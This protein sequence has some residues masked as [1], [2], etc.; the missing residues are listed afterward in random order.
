[1]RLIIISWGVCAVAVVTL[2]GCTT[3]TAIAQPTALTQAYNH[4]MSAYKKL[5]EATL[6]LVRDGTMSEAN[7]QI[8]LLEKAWDKGTS[9]F[10]WAAFS[11]YK[12]IDIQLDAAIDACDAKDA[13][14]AIRELDKF[15][16]MLAQASTD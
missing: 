12:P 3:K 5:G 15:L 4:D 8:L 7:D 14:K 1:M 11:I 9:D 6:K 10:K 13:P 2:L 16:K